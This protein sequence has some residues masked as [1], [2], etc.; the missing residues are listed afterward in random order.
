MKQVVRLF[1]VV[2]ASVGCVI[3][4]PGSPLEIQGALT[5]QA[6]ACAFDPQ[7]TTRLSG[8]SRDVSANTLGAFGYI[9]GLV[10]VN[11]TRPVQERPLAYGNLANVY[12]DTT[13]ITI[14]GFNVCYE[15]KDFR[16]TT[17]GPGNTPENTFPS[18]TSIRDR[19]RRFFLGSAGTVP[20]NSNL[21]LSFDL[22]PPSISGA[23]AQV[24][25]TASS[26][27]FE[28]GLV[29]SGDKKTVIIHVQAVGHTTDNMY[30][31][32]NEMLYPVDLCVGCVP[33]TAACSG[34]QVPDRTSLCFPGQDR[35]PVCIDP[36]TTP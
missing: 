33:F 6:P 16:I 10:L 29:N 27:R 26:S 17:D 14:D 15:F 13:D 1:L 21:A 2:A 24:A 12:V 7:V 22:F 20:T 5:I 31:E 25:F 28:Q 11:K 32:S 8:G 30:V 23:S 36:P 34:K 9:V 19:E 18:C 4:N 35:T 3:D